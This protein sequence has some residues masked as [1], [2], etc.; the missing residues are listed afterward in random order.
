MASGHDH[1]SQPDVD[2]NDDEHEEREEDVDKM[3][4]EEDRASVGKSADDNG[5]DN[6]MRESP[7]DADDNNVGRGDDGAATER[8]SNHGDEPKYGSEETQQNGDGG[9]ANTSH[10]S[11]NPED[12]D[13][14]SFLSSVSDLHER[15]Q[16]DNL[17]HVND[18]FPADDLT[19]M[20]HTV[21]STMNNFKKY[22]MHTQ[23]ELERVRGMMKEIKDK[24]YKRIQ[25]KGYDPK[26]GKLKMYRQQI[27]NQQDEHYV[28]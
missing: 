14:R 25:A 12:F 7:R 1:K 24:V 11:D 23:Q 18:D 13:S 27:I 21:T 6:K 9:Y 26:S 8:D 2:K 15:L 4:D 10:Q 5:D 22:A 19:H 28:L 17:K 3:D 20:V 16:A